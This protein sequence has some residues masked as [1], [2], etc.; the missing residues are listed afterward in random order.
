MTTMQASPVYSPRTLTVAH[1][2]LQAVRANT[3]PNRAAPPSG[4]YTAR[5][6]EGT[7]KATIPWSPGSR[8]HGIPPAL[9]S[10]AMVF[11]T[12]Q[13]RMPK[14]TGN[15][16][17]RRTGTLIW[18]ALAVSLAYPD[19]PQVPSPSKHQRKVY[20]RTLGALS[21]LWTQRGI[22]SLVSVKKMDDHFAV[23]VPV[24]FGSPEVLRNMVDFYKPEGTHLGVPGAEPTEPG[25][26]DTLID[27]TVAPEGD[28]PV[29]RPVESLDAAFKLREGVY[30]LSDIPKTGGA[31]DRYLPFFRQAPGSHIEVKKVGAYYVFF[32]CLNF[33][34]QEATVMCQSNWLTI[35]AIDFYALMRSWA[36][37]RVGGVRADPPIYSLPLSRIARELPPGAPTR[38][39][40]DLSI[41]VDE[42]SDYWW[43]PESVDEIASFEQDYSKH[44]TRPDGSLSAAPLDP[45]DQVHRPPQSGLV[46]VDWVNLKMSFINGEGKLEVVGLDRS[47]PANITH[48]VR[49]LRTPLGSKLGQGIVS[50]TVNMCSSTSFPLSALSNP[51]NLIA[52]LLKLSEFEGQK[53]GDLTFQDAYNSRHLVP[54]ADEFFKAAEHILSYADTSVKNLYGTYAYRTVSHLI[55]YLKILNAYAPKYETAVAEDKQRRDAYIQQDSLDPEYSLEAVPYMN[56]E[57]KDGPKGARALMPHQFRNARRL[58][59]SPNFAILAVDAGGG[60]TASCAFD[61]LKEMGKGNVRRGLIM[62]PSH[63][64]A[65][66]VKEFLYFTNGRVNIIAVNTYT[67]K[68]HTLEGMAKMLESAPPNT[69]VVT[70]YNLANGS[71]KSPAMGYGAATTRY[72]PVVEMLRS[73]MFDYV[74]CDES[75]FLKSVSQRQSAVARLIS[76]IPYKRLA[77]GTLAPN[78]VTDL[79]QQIALLDP[80]VF[81]KDEFYEKYALEVRNGKVTRWKT[82]YE[83]EMMAA[84]KQHVVWCQTKRKEWASLLPRLLEV[85]HLVDLTPAQQNVYNTILNEVV[86]EIQRALMDGNKVGKALRKLLSGKSEDEGTPANGEEGEGEDAEGEDDDPID[87]DTLLR[88]YLARLERF[89]SSPSSDILGASM[90]QGRD[91]VSPKV[92]KIT[93]LIRNHIA[94]A[95]PGKILIFTNLVE[96]AE[97][98][99]RGLPDD[100]RSQTILYKA[101]NKAECGAE[102]EG[103]PNKLIMVGVEMSM[104]TGLNL[105]FCSRLIRA[106]S[107]W[108]PGALEQ[109]DSRIQ[110]PNV[111]NAETRTRVYVDWVIAERT[112]DITKSCYL[113][114]K[115]VTI[116]K[117]EEAGNPRFEAIDNPPSFSMTLDTIRSSSVSTGEELAPYQEAYR[118]FK[119]ATFAEYE[120]Y[121]QKNQQDLDPVT[122][123]LR[124]IGLE[125]AANQP[126]AALMYRVPYVPGTELYKTEDLGLV[127]YDAYMRLNEADLTDDDTPDVETDDQ[128]SISRAELAQVQGLA[129]HTEYGDGNIV[130]VGKRN[131]GIELTSS[132]RVTVNKLTAFVINRGQTNGKDMRELLLRQI[133]DIDFNKP[134]ELEVKDARSVKIPKRR[135]VQPEEEQDNRIAVSLNI[136]VTNDLIGL[137]MDN[138]SANPEGAAALE[139]LGFKQP[140][141]Y[142]YAEMK[143]PQHMYKQMVV[144]SQAGFYFDKSSSNAMRTLYENLLAARKNAA[145]LIGQ[146]TAADL[147]N[148][149]RL[150]T[151]ADPDRKRLYPYPLI[152]ND[153]LFIALPLSGHPASKAA[154]TH[155]APGV[156]WYSTE[157]TVKDMRAVYMTNLSALDRGIQK[158]LN[159]GLVISNLKDLMKIRKRLHK[160]AAVL[161]GE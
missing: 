84:L 111:K 103:D 49:I 114:Q 152:E 127:R 27:Q 39:S 135:E 41:V 131:L 124:M 68:H 53:E 149:Y 7:L 106:D 157:S 130:A 121:K 160:R 96:S 80:T 91:L 139:A 142:L 67:I 38:L 63:L 98:I 93:D 3:D 59:R 14:S 81:P 145:T 85:T 26:L 70:D 31:F 153:T 79:L 22:S 74:F 30:H 45:S 129:V 136:T 10:G 90:L 6:P 110:R 101:A 32:L 19:T 40:K 143:T 55:A 11:Y 140:A 146:A 75:H 132:E 48:Y 92:D 137:E 62:C 133:G 89:V 21:E 113:R 99:Y 9:K 154:L 87:V 126:S 125:R 147:R 86:A 29:Q 33:S 119:M 24:Y 4:P 159:Q 54:A 5:R 120:D 122:G 12:N 1:R 151:K 25:K 50:Q 52:E 46:F 78:A 94:E 82:G 138:A 102:F 61:F 118:D 47:V 16:V 69:V 56:T 134:L 65:Q 128:R 13:V 35:R 150:N 76:D 43:V 117:F 109:G 8:K 64:V 58:A 95:I 161:G 66:Y 144:W 36:D 34:Q 156:K 42:K 2:V 148:F 77:S 73:F 100:L 123:G 72:Y 116:G 158:M 141:P 71:S 37:G 108:T 60:K 44:L 115:S 97:A 28:A 18:G 107:V 51:L 57:A 88:P 83:A 23:K 15:G 105:Q 20:R 17:A 155:K 104:N 112:I